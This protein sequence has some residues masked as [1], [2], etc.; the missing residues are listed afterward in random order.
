[1]LLFVTF[2]NHWYRHG[3]RPHVLTRFCHGICAKMLIYFSG[4]ECR[5]IGMY[6]FIYMDVNV[7]GTPGYCF[8]VFCFLLVDF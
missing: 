6:L 8:V 2:H 7:P 5:M 1:M 3:A 4:K